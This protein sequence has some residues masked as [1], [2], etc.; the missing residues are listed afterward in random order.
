MKKY[1]VVVY[2]D[3][4]PKQVAT[5][6]AE[7]HKEAESKAWRMFPEY[8]EIGVFENEKETAKS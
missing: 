6:E 5:I 2:P 7:S 3:G 8:H 4:Y 1:D